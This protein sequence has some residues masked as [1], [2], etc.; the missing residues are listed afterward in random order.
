MNT[1]EG[2]VAVVTGAFTYLDFPGM[3][4]SMHGH[5]PELYTRTVS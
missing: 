1:H 2:R 4:H 3:P 5:Q